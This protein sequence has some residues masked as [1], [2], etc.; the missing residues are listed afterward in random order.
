[1]NSSPSK[2]TEKPSAE[3]GRATINDIARLAGVSKKTVSRVLNNSPFVREETRQRVSAL[4]LEMGYTPDPQ[5]RALAFRRSPQARAPYPDRQANTMKAPQ[6][7]TGV[8]SLSPVV[9][10]VTIDDVEQAVPLAS[11]LLAGGI[12]TIEITLRTEAAL[13]AIRAVAQHAPELT[14]GAGTVLNENDLAAAI[15]AGARYA[16]SPGATRSLMK[17]ARKAPIPFIPGVATSSEIMRGLD[18]GYTCFKFFPAEQMG[19]IAAIK[20]LAGPFPSV[21]FC[22]TGSISAAKAHEY[23]ALPNVLCVGGSWIAPTDKIKAGD[24]ANVEAAAKQAV[25]LKPVA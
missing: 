20:S 7:P 9:P 4:M 15:E 21:R 2:P 23:L 6:D 8:L 17:A 5:A 14:V 10:V 13:D 19:G 25:A 22:A 16:L 11:A 1:M 24:W 12:R 18:L 3:P